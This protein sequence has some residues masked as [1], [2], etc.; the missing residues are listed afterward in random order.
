MKKLY[1]RTILAFC[2]FAGLSS[3]T[4]AEPAKE[5]P[6]TQAE[7]TAVKEWR[8]SQLG[9]Q[10]A[11]KDTSV[12]LV[13]AEE[14]QVTGSGGVNRFGGK[15]ELKADGQITIQNIFATEKAAL[16]ENVMKQESQF[17]QLLAMSKR[18]LLSE[19]NLVIECADKDEKPIKLVFVAVKKD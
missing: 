15:C 9:D 5:T 17:F 2:L 6:A 19:G 8:L 1:T 12:T 16:D 10:A 13:F 7:L 18:A 11:V 4:H 14:G 3:I